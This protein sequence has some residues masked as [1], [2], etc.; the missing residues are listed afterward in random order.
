MTKVGG[1]EKDL[2]KRRLLVAP[3]PAGQFDASRPGALVELSLVSFDVG[4]SR[5]QAKQTNGQLIS[6]CG[7]FAIS[8]VWLKLV[9]I[10]LRNGKQRPLSLGFFVVYFSSS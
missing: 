5:R 6:I 7:S 8:L 9:F 1:V 2:T 3:P 10:A 4:G